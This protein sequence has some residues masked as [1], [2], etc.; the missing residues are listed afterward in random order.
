MA[1]DNILM[2]YSSLIDDL[3]SKPY[4]IIDILPKQVP[5]DNGGQYFKIEKYWTKE[6]NNTVIGK[7]L[8][9][10]QTV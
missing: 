7:K 3:L 1:L 6:P 8:I 4:W 5:A 2:D 10:F 9:L